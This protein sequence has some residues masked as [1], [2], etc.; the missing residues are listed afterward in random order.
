ME[1]EELYTIAKGALNPKQI[2]KNLMQVLLLLPFYAKMVRY[3]G[4]CFDMPCSMGFCAEHEAI[5]AMITDGEC[6]IK[7]IIAVYKDGTSYHRAEDVE[8]LFVK[9]M[10]MTINAK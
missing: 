5:A 9:F 4:V 6:K 8:S 3:K 10:M 1:F 7:G 2:S